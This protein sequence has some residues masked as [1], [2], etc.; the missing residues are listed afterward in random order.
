MQLG[1]H[2]LGQFSYL[3]RA[4]DRSLAEKAFC[5]RAIESRMHSPDVVQQLRDANPTWEDGDISNERDILH[6]LIALGPWV[7]SQHL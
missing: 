2:S 4:F 3:A 1:Y 7:A 5:S 6:Q